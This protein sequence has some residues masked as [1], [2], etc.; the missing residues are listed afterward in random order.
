[1]GATGQNRPCE[2]GRLER[3]R[4]RCTRRRRH[5]GYRLGQA[6][7]PRAGGA[8]QTAAQHAT[9]AAEP[10]TGG[11]LVFADPRALGHADPTTPD[12]TLCNVVALGDSVVTLDPHRDGWRQIAETL[13]QRAR[14]RAPNLQPATIQAIVLLAHARPGRAMLG[15]ALLGSAALAGEP[16]RAALKAIGAA[17]GP[18]GAMLLCGR[19]AAPKRVLRHLA[20]ATGLTVAALDESGL[21]LLALDS[22]ALKRPS[23]AH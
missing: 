21:G 19:L 5:P 13:A 17:L 23:R 2:R 18:R 9:A 6:P 14:P 1:M 11:V 15:A 20:D 22:R 8:G 12:P 10:A 7:A 3:V 4:R 16:C